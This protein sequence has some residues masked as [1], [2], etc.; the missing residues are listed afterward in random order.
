MTAITRSDDL[1][2][3][4]QRRILA[5]L[6]SERP[7][8][9]TKLSATT[10]LSASTI[11]AITAALMDRGY[12][13][14]KAKTQSLEPGSD[15]N[16]SSARR[17]RPQVSLT[18]N[19][20]AATIGALSLTL[21]RLSAALIDYAGT[22]IAEVSERVDTQTLEREEYPRKLEALLR[23]ACAMVENKAGPLGHIIV[24]VQ[25]VSDAAGTRMD[26]SPITPHRDLELGAELSSAFGVPV[27]VSND[28]NMIAEALQNMER[29]RY[30][31]SFAAILLSHG[32]GMGLFLNGKPFTG[33]WSSAAEFGHL[34]HIPDGALCRCGRHGCIEAYAGD[35]GI[36]RMATGSDPQQMPPQEIDLQLMADLANRAKLGDQ[37]VVAAYRAAGAA[38][39]HGLRS[40]FAL[41]DH[42]PVAFVGSGVLAFDLMEP[43]IRKSLG[44][45][46]VGLS[47]GDASLS[48]FADDLTLTQDGT[49]ATALSEL[50]RAIPINREAAEVALENVS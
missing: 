20:D 39:G 26:W 11:T 40:L 49:I 15:A 17:G 24:A 42:F 8:S 34:C 44:R 16:A 30:G 1:R 23:Q 9:R 5:V 28:A 25:G 37:N 4:N 50:D 27:S 31:D 18:L 43:M 21:N 38:L 10:G 19:P 48:C 7:V 22:V 41:F 32:I 47:H 2:R 14:E 46:G 12:L 13:V 29:E 35:Y 3:E 45:Q 33:I 6:R 36:W